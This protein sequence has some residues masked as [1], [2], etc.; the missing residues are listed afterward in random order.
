MPRSYLQR[1]RKLRSGLL[2]AGSLLLNGSAGLNE[3][4]TNI[5]DSCRHQNSKN[6]LSGLY[7]SGAGPL[8]RMEMGWWSHDEDPCSVKTYVCRKGDPSMSQKRDLLLFW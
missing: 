3:G 8:I 4:K 5:S 6:G 2:Y 1:S 7:M